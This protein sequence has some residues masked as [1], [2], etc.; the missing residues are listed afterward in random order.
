MVLA[1]GRLV[2]Q[3]GF[4]ILI[5]SFA[6][7]QARNK[8]WKLIILGEGVER[9]SLHALIEK[10]G[11]QR[12]IELPG[13]VSEPWKW[14][15][16]ARVFVLSSR[17]E[18]FPNA[19]IEAM[20]MGCPTVATDCHSGPSEIIRHG[21]NGM[22]V[23]VDDIDALTAA[24]DDLTEHPNRSEQLALEAMQV[25]KKFSADHVMAQWEELI[26]AALDDGA[27]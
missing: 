11:L 17:F 8:Q 12:Q 6:S 16:R 19:L 22:L 20:A 2:P 13:V 21:H 15:N 1:V 10:E 27:S 7:S 14:F 9:S 24:L 18:G 5:Q 4:D 23:P 3:K 25:R 26:H